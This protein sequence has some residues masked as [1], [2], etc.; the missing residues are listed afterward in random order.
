MWR[1][2]YDDRADKPNLGIGASGIDA[3]EIAELAKS[4]EMVFSRVD[5]S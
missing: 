3:A 5:S 4:L 1:A 2:S